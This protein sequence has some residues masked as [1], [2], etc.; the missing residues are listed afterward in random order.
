[1]RQLVHV[2]S[3]D[4]LGADGV[5]HE[6]VLRK[7]SEVHTINRRSSQ[8]YLASERERA[9]RSRRSMKGGKKDHRRKQKTGARRRRR[10]GGTGSGT[11]A[12]DGGSASGSDDSLGMSGSSLS[13]SAS[14]DD[15]GARF[16]LASPAPPKGRLLEHARAAPKA[17][18]PISRA[19]A[20][21]DSGGAAKQRSGL[22]KAIAHGTA[23]L[24]P[25]EQAPAEEE[26]PR[27]KAPPPSLSAFHTVHM[28][29]NLLKHMHST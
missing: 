6:R 10:H 24:V 13:G 12:H 22:F 28:K 16:D 17:G 29:L 5:T 20:D 25:T 18:S 19:G 2:M 27:R 3:V 26:R 15:Y 21:G 8:E 14:D 23:T 7:A 4:V 1:L 9:T 11:G